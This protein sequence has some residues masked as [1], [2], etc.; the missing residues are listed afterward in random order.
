MPKPDLQSIVIVAAVDHPVATWALKEAAQVNFD[1]SDEVPQ[2][3]LLEA[4][5]ELVR[6][7]AIDFQERRSQTDWGAT[8]LYI[9]ELLLNFGGGAAAG[10]TVEGIIAGIR[11]LSRRPTPGPA[12]HAMAEVV[13]PATNAEAAW[14]LFSSFL[15]KAFQ[16]S[17]TMA[18]EIAEID[19]GWRIRA[20]GDGYRFEGTVSNDGRILHAQQVDDWTTEPT[21]E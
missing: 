4:V 15:T 17:S 5:L 21:K 12:K 2:N 18:T 8:G 9:Q 11:K 1:Q 6:P 14:T 10:L 3:D 19:S 13:P 16:V 7:A 20:R